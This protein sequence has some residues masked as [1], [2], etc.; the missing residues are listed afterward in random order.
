MKSN[1]H[2][3]KLNPSVM[4]ISLTSLGI[5]VVQGSRHEALKSIVGP[6][7]C[8]GLKK[9]FSESV[10]VLSCQRVGSLRSRTHYL[11]ES[12]IFW[13]FTWLWRLQS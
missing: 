12:L 3:R 11:K 1:A 9:P 10:L 8:Q 7:G 2:G 6:I 5:K 4:G 13:G